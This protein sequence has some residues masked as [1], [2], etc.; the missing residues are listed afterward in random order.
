MN[1]LSEYSSST[2]EYAFLDS[3]KKTWC[4]QKPLLNKH[5]LLNCHLTQAT[6]EIIKVFLVGGA[7]VDVTCFGNLVKHDK[8]LELLKGMRVTFYTKRGMP[9]Q[10]LRGYYSL[11][12]DCGMGLLGY[13]EPIV[14]TVELTHVSP[15]TDFQHRRPILTVDLSITKKIETFFGTGDGFLRTLIQDVSCR[16]QYNKLQAI[17]FLKMKK[18]MIL[19][20]GKV[21]R[22]LIWALESIGVPRN[23]IIVID[24]NVEVCQEAK[25]SGLVAATIDSSDMLFIESLVRD[26]YVVVTATG[27]QGAVSSNFDRSIFSSVE[28]LMN[29]GTHD[30]WGDDFSQEEIFYDKKPANFSLA[31][32]TLPCYLDPIFGLYLLA[33]QYLLEYALPAAFMPVPSTL[34]IEVYTDWCCRNKDIVSSARSFYI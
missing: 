28:V 30:E 3:L 19:G 22:G 20:Y 17:S 26:I 9:R 11:A 6:L 1:S 24:L 13:V 21:G 23:N 12:F 18:Y 27:V 29:M 31:F 4:I 33:G 14:G 10:C 7:T 8:I 34:D 2:T 25:N 32:P 5:I 16:F 15:P